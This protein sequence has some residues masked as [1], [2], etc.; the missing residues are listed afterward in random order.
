[1]YVYIY[2]YIQD[3]RYRFHFFRIVSNHLYVQM[4]MST[5]GFLLETLLQNNTILSPFG[6]PSFVAEGAALKT[7]ASIK[8]WILDDPLV[9]EELMMNI[10]E[11]QVSKPGELH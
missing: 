9:I 7:G 11:L 4:H 8:S 5:A 2:I 3:F 1:M 10:H 6:D